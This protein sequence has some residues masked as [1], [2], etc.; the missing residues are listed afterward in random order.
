MRRECS[1]YRAI[2]IYRRSRAKYPVRHTWSRDL[3]L[4]PD[5]CI[6]R[7]GRLP[8]QALLAS[9]PL[10]GSLSP[11]LSG[12]E[13]ARGVKL[14]SVAHRLTEANIPTHLLVYV[15]TRSPLSLG[16]GPCHSLP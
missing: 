7:T 15:S 4:S 13:S 11:A 16:Y 12:A 3:C 5:H 8:N 14:A 10:P 6:P 9:P 1:N 2:D